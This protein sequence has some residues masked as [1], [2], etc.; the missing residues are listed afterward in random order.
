MSWLEKLKFGLKKT[1]RIL[2]GVKMDM[3]SLDALEESLLQADV[4]IKTT[5]ELI[6]V[7]KSRHPKD[8]TETRAIIRQTLIE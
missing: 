2:T 7:L 1:A 8:V 5:T 3:S 6:E 4:G